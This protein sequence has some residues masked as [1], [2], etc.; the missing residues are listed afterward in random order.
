MKV[1]L[2]SS[3]EEMVEELSLAL[4]QRW[5]DV[6]VLRESRA[7]SIIELLKSEL[8]NMIILDTKLPD[9]STL[10]K[11]IR[12]LSNLPIIALVGEGK[13]STRVEALEEGAD[14]YVIQPPE[15]LELQAKVNALL[16]RNNGHSTDTDF[17]YRKRGL[18]I[19]FGTRT[20]AS[21]RQVVSLTPTEHKLL[22]YLVK[23]EGKFVPKDD[24]IR[25]VW[26]PSYLGIGGEE[27]LRRYV[28]RL[29]LKLNR[30]GKRIVTRWGSGY[31]FRP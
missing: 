21:G 22:H 1:L 28:S 16:R 15:R 18:Q 9:W 6:I 2:A 4:V 5:P 26:G 11:Q 8:P 30:Q 19:D 10:L 14:D 20:I 25:R 12:T 7:S 29:R 31:L 3:N 27:E 23:N 24:L 17:V 13:E